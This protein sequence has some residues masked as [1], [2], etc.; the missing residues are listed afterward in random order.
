LKELLLMSPL[1]YR[2]GWFGLPLSNAKDVAQL[3][4]CDNVVAQV[5]DAPP[6]KP[7]LSQS[8]PMP[9]CSMQPRNCTD[10][11]LLSDVKD[12]RTIDLLH[13]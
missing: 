1:Q 4:A 8:R 13:H 3:T 12:L 11:V 10:G 9:H 5:L 7:R 6:A 2:T